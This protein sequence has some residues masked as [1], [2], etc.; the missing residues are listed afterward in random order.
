MNAFDCSH[1][2]AG[3]APGAPAYSSIVAICSPS[4]AGLCVAKGGIVG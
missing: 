3:I 4:T 1:A 2:C